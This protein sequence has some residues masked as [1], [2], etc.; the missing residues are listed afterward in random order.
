MLAELVSFLVSL[1]ALAFVLYI[2]GKMVVGKRAT[3][4][5]ALAIAFLGTV[6]G[7]LISLFIPLIGWLIALLVWLYL[8]KS[9][10][11]TGW[12]S[13]FGIA[14][15]AVIVAIVVGIILGLIFGVTIIGLGSIL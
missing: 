1:V 4:G 2:A 10:Y 5:K 14:I 3:F 13:A 9:Y 6:I 8:I 15:L 7:F 12:L 11:S